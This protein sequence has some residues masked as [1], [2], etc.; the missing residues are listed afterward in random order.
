M[1]YPE[2]LL[3]SFRELSCLVLSRETVRST[4]DVV[5]RLAVKTIPGCDVACVSL[6]SVDEITTVGATDDVAYTLDAIQYETGQ[7]PCLD[8]IG[9]DAMWFR[10]D[11]M[12][13]D[14]TWP[15]FSVRAKQE[16]F[17]SQLAFTLRIGE[18][19]LGALNLYSRETSAF[20]ADDVDN[21]A[22]FAAH[23]A[24]AL[25]HAQ[26]GAAGDRGGLGELDE[27]LVAQ[28]II[29]RAVGILMG[30]EF[31]TADE[32]FKVLEERAEAL[33]SRLV[34]SA[35]EVVVAADRESA[36]LELPSGFAD[37]IMGRARDG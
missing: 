3:S 25:S 8:A 14:T 16:G 5:S 26:T 2:R 33:K 7:G 27:A 17:N 12:T 28:E 37:R 22:I 34:D 35:E 24:V 36:D 15:A 21:G 10:I 1:T 13:S 19:T 23:A 20:A 29:A 11:D 30:K 4:L 18:N 9:E 32:A 6:V 31:R